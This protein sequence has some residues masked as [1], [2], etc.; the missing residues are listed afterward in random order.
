MT[1]ALHAFGTLCL[2]HFVLIT[3]L[4]LQ[5]RTE[6]EA[7]CDPETQRCKVTPPKMLYSG[8][9]FCPPLMN[10]SADIP[11]SSSSDAVIA[12]HA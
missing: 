4:H 3:L 2:W 7:A 10:P 12:M 9:T 8:C 11:S 5:T 6:G 1:A